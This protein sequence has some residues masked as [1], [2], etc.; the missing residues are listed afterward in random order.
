MKCVEHAVNDDQLTLPSVQELGRIT[1]TSS[2][3][4]SLYMLKGSVQLRPT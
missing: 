2:I 3:M 4:L 1:G